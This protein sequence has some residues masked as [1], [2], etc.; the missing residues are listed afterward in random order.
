MFLFVVSAIVF[1]VVAVANSDT[2]CTW[3]FGSQYILWDCVQPSEQLIVE[4]TGLARVR[5]DIGFVAQAN[6]PHK[7][8]GRTAVL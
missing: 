3:D 8:T 7:F 4:R 1:A 5:M 2:F 6:I